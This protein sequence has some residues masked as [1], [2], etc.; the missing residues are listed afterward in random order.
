MSTGLSVPSWTGVIASLL[1]VALAAAV[2]YRQRLGLTA[3]WSSP[4]CAP[5]SSWSR[6]G[7]ALVIFARTGLPGGFGWVIV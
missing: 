1:L 7:A 6:S 2:A 5:A 3:S 4:P